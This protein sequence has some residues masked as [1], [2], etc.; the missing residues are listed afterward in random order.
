MHLEALYHTIQGRY[1]MMILEIRIVTTN[2]IIHNVKASALD[3]T[4]Y[5]RIACRGLRLVRSIADLFSDAR[6]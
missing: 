5:Y 3:L 6:I 2:N 4:R 1:H